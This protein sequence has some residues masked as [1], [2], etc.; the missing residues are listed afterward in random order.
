MANQE[1]L[2]YL[3]QFAAGG[4]DFSEAKKVLLGVGWGEAEV[5][6]AIKQ[7]SAPSLERPSQPP[8]NANSTP[9]SLRAQFSSQNIQQTKAPVFQEEPTHGVNKKVLFSAV[10]VALLVF[11]GGAYAYFGLG[12][13]VSE[14]PEAVLSEAIK[15][16]FN[17]ETSNSTAHLE[18]SYSG[19][20]PTNLPLIGSMSG[21]LVPETVLPSGKE[22]I[23]VGFTLDTNGA[24]DISDWEKQKV[25]SHL[26]LGLSLPGAPKIN[27]KL[28]FMM[29]DGAAYFRLTDVNEWS[30]L[31]KP[32]IGDISSLDGKWIKVDFAEFQNQMLYGLGSVNS[33]SNFSLGNNPN[34]ELGL[35]G[36]LV[37]GASLPAGISKDQV[38]ELK[39]I[40]ENNKIFLV[41]KELPKETVDGENSYHYRIA[42]D[43]AA[44]KNAVVD[45]TIMFQKAMMEGFGIGAPTAEELEKAKQDMAVGIGQALDDAEKFIKE[46]A[47]VS[48]AD[49]WIG[50]SSK[51]IKRVVLDF[52]VSHESLGGEVHFRSEAAY[53]KIGE[54]VVVEA[55]KDALSFESV[56]GQLSQGNGGSLFKGDQ[57][58]TRMSDLATLKSA[59]SLYLADVAKPHLCANNR[60]IYASAPIKVPAGWKL[61]PNV[62]SRKV[63]GTGWIPV[64]L[65]E[66]SSGAPIRQLPVDPVNDPS[67]KLVYLYVCDPAKSS[68]EVDALMVSDKYISSSAYDDGDDPKVY[69]IGTDRGLKLIPKGFWD[70]S[71]GT[72]GKFSTEPDIVMDPTGSYEAARNKED[73]TRQSDL[74]TIKSAVSLYEADVA[75]TYYCADNKTIY[76]S[77]P[78]KVPVGWKLGPNAGSQKVDG[79]GWIPVDLTKISSGAPIAKWPVDPQNDPSKKLVYLYVCDPAKSSFEVDAILTDSGSKTAMARDGGDDLNVYEVGT[80]PGLKLIPKEF[81]DHNF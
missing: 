48:S 18:V 34:L 5:D 10:V 30:A 36:G 37:G 52:T 63:D 72:T 21:G 28:D 77:A 71:F 13:G 80:S 81:W 58:S 3:K 33:I 75:M 64:N 60:T 65:E 23:S 61:G 9:A 40:F 46:H 74:A 2:N 49:V 79:T 57:D 42:L 66:I 50:K 78:I 17:I 54:P 20:M 16:F 45:F 41:E 14:K 8:A 24:A 29:A 7:L 4:K 70:G 55:P 27:I 59:L 67:K 6:E 62:G 31:A 56:V 25:S 73:A 39:R 22:K 53:T 68:F 47:Q 11:G 76:A 35:V 51:Q 43:K 19:T 44:V 1:I 69:E 12:I 15:N 38:L 32:L 26:N